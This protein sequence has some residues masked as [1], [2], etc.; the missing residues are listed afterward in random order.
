M[1]LL[2]FNI[3]KIEFNCNFL[4][5]QAEANVGKLQDIEKLT[6]KIDQYRSENEHL[7]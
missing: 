1:C 4:P 5:F 6:E 3:S 7:R 2:Y